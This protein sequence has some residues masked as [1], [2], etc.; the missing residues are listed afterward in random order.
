CLRGVDAG[1]IPG[2]VSAQGWAPPRAPIANLDQLPLPAWDLVDID[3]YRRAW[4]EAHGYFSLN[5]VASRGCPYRFNWCANA[6]FG[7]TY[8]Y[9]SADRVAA[10]LECVRD[11]FAPDEIWFADDIFGLSGKWTREFAACV[12]QRGLRI[13]FRI[14][15]RCDLMLRDTVDALARA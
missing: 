15:S 6:V 8:R 4:V 13:P 2:T 10:E 7:D 14:Q 5:L 3:Q 1:A 9:F 11:L 12:E